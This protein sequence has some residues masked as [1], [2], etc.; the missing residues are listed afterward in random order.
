MAAADVERSVESA[1]TT[2]SGIFSLKEE[3]NDCAQDAFVVLPTGF[4][5]GLIYVKVS[6]L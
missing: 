6:L 1:I 5:K 4:G 2:E 3:S